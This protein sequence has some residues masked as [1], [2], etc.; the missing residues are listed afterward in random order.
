VDA[1][2]LARVC[3]AAGQQVEPVA[4]VHRGYAHNARWRVRLADGTAAFA[5]AAVDEATAG[6]LRTE[7]DLYALG[8]PY[9][10]QLLGWADRDLPTLL[11]E[12]L[13]DAHWPPAWRPGDVEAVRD[14]LRLVA[15]TEPPE[16]VTLSATFWL[17]QHNWP[18]VAADPAPFLSVGLCD[19]AWLGVAL[20]VLAE[21]ASTAPVAGDSLLHLDVRSDNLCVRDGRAVLVDWNWAARG[22]PVFDL[23]AWLPSL[24]AEGGPAPEEV[25]PEAGVFAPFFAG[26]WASVVGL[27][28]PVTAPRVREVQL[29]QLRVALPWAAR[30]LGL[31]P[32][33]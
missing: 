32:P 22:N 21:A 9:M 13:T 5:K 15:Q 14:A 19:E 17:D 6:W 29:A 3:E 1:D 28:P 16:S 24:H 2:L 18:E 20:P 31:P 12:D 8:A 7:R 4:E 30:T 11:L 33:S 25:A 26:F 10:A 27:P 23:A